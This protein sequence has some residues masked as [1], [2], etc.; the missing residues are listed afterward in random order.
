M[1]S[2][3]LKLPSA[4][5]DNR[6]AGQLAANL[7]CLLT[8][9]LPSKVYLMSRLSLLAHLRGKTTGHVTE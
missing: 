1:E 4:V 7:Y 8:S 2:L 6:T 5:Q 3:L 9:P